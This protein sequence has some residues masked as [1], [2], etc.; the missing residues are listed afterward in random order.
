MIS[1]AHK[2]FFGYQIKKNDMWRLSGEKR[3][4]QGFGE[5][6]TPLGN[7]LRRWADD[8]KMDLHKTG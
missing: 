7:K 8:I 3:C 1:T 4:T 6:N 5:G 2:V